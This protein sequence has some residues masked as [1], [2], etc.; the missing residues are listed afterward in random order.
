MLL[1]L[2]S[3]MVQSVFSKTAGAGL[4]RGGPYQLIGKEQGISLYERWIPNSKTEKVRQLKAVFEVRALKDEALSLLRSERQGTQWNIN[5]IEYKLFPFN[6]RCW[7]TY[8][9]YR[10]PFPF[11]DQD[12]CYISNISSA[13]SSS[14]EVNFKSVVHGRFPEKKGVTRITGMIGQWSLKETGNGKLQVTYIISTDKSL[15]L[16]RWISDPIVHK[17]L[18][19]T[20][21]E[22]SQILQINTRR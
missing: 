19:K 9:K 12:C 2:I 15:S 3:L 8:T 18:F 6:A 16:P 17:N 21:K 13:D 5:A 1:I 22:F 11:D 20:L 10:V 7:I 14:A 4:D